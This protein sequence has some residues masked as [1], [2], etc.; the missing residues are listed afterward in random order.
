MYLMLEKPEFKARRACARD[1]DDDGGGN[2]KQEK[3]EIE[4]ICAR[5]GDRQRRK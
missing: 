4:T 2:N 3:R 5:V 1:D